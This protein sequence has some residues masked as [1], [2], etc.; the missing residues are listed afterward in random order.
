M[1]SPSFVFE[2]SIRERAGTLNLRAREHDAG[3][4]PHV[5]DQ[6]VVAAFNTGTLAYLP[7]GNFPD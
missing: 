1:S 4:V 2:R 3:I 5:L 6:F 7:L